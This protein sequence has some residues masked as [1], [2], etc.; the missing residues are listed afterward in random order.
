VKYNPSRDI[1]LAVRELKD[2]SPSKIVLWILN[3][4]NEE[5]TSQSVTMWFKDH[6]SIY[7]E[8]AKEIREGAPTEKQAVD[9]SIFQNDSFQEIPSVKNWI[10][11]MNAREL[12]PKTIEGQLINLKSS[13]L[14]K[15]RSR[16]ADEEKI[17]FVAQGKWAMKHPDRISLND[18]L[19]LITLLKEKN[20]DTHQYKRALKDFLISKGVVV[21]KKIAVG[22][23]KGYGKYAKLHVEKPKI[24]LM[25]KE[26]KATNF[27]A[28]AADLF[29]LKTGTRVNATLNALIE[30]IQGVR[31]L[32]TITVFDKG[33]RS[34]YAKGHPWEK[35][36]D[37][38]L[39]DALQKLIGERKAG[40]IFSLSDSQLAEINRAIVT[41][42]A[43][44]IVER[45]PDFMPNH[46]WRHFFAQLLLPQV[47]WNY[48]IVAALGG[49]T[50]QAL[51]ESYGKPPN[52][53]VREWSKKYTVA[54]ETLEV[55]A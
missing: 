44:E 55:Q 3:K 15:F 25:L 9:D 30:D 12:D 13:C 6:P 37:P 29:M 27:E 47:E 43:P 45:Y 10:V 20:I 17:D 36:V 24:L 4:R 2:L 41:K 32:A 48:A 33:R 35:E 7:D 53:L 50:P 11:E 1:P 21:G 42:H 22:K 51:E 54:I 14:G 39:Y 34:K 52:E 19:E 46:I 18:A 28:Y 38:Q 8:L 40:K 23:S 5:R 16:K 49:W 26:L 31:D